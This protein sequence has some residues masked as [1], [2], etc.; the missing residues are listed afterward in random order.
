[1]APICPIVLLRVCS[2]SSLIR[3]RHSSD[4]GLTTG[5][6]P[7]TGPKT[8]LRREDYPLPAK[9]SFERCLARDGTGGYIQQQIAAAWRLSLC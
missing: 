9:R 2:K 6:L 4:H 8:T 5:L 7:V 3:Q 1:M